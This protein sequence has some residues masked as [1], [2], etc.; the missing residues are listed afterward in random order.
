MHHLIPDEQRD[1]YYIRG[2]NSLERRHIL[3]Q[4]FFTD[5]LKERHELVPRYCISQFRHD[6]SPR[7]LVRHH[8]PHPFFEQRILES[9]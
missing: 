8:F 1:P 7:V 9:R 3:G 2:T 6:L 5:L 4:D